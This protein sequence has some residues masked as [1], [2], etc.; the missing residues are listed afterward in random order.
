MKFLLRATFVAFLL[1]V[2]AGS[3]APSRADD[4]MHKDGWERGGAYDKLFQI[5]KVQTITGKVV[6]VDRACKPLPDMEEGVC[7]LVQTADGEQVLCQVGP[8]WFTEYFHRRWNVQTGDQ[9]TVRGSLVDVGGK[10][11]MMVV[12]GSKGDLKMAVRDQNGHPIWD[13][14]VAEF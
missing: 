3:A 11:A 6:S 14:P 10:P 9:V 13:L 1:A 5:D 12:W 7:A 2:L 4:T 8:H